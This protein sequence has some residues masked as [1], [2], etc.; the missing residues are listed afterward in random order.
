MADISWAKKTALSRVET[1]LICTAIS[2]PR[3][4]RTKKRNTKQTRDHK[5]ERAMN[6]TVYANAV[7]QRNKGKQKVNKI[8]ITAIMLIVY[9]ILSLVWSVADEW[10]S[11]WV[12]ALPSSDVCQ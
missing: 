3:G 1:T 9:W 7:N 11:Q 2:M 8:K 5:T 10:N 4:I 12:T 6:R